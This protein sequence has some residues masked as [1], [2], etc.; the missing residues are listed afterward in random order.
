[1]H[2]VSRR[3]NQG[4]FAPGT[5]LSSECI[6][7]IHS[8]EYDLFCFTHTLCG[9]AFLTP[10]F[11]ESLH[12]ATQLHPLLLSITDRNVSN[13][14]DEQKE[15]IWTN[16]RGCDQQKLSFDVH[17][18][19]FTNFIYSRASSFTP[20][21]AVTIRIYSFWNFMLRPRDDDVT[22]SHRRI[23]LWIETEDK[24]RCRK[25]FWTPLVKPKRVAVSIMSHDSLLFVTDR[26]WDEHELLFPWSSFSLATDMRVFRVMLFLLLM[27]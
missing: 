9:I 8:P 11:L 1:M 21:S 27:V 17:F 24:V 25:A 18:E 2:E 10:F 20:C 12:L 4:D 19:S 15:D 5:S 7:S 3:R 16:V 6:S 14:F 22:N 26:T 23:V 13:V